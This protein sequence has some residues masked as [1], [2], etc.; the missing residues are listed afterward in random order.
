MDPFAPPP[1]RRRSNTFARTRPIDVD[2]VIDVDADDDTHDHSSGAAVQSDTHTNLG[3]ASPLLPSPDSFYVN[4]HPVRSSFQEGSDLLS[5]HQPSSAFHSAS[6]PYPPTAQIFTRTSSEEAPNDIDTGHTIGPNMVD[7]SNGVTSA[8][9][10]ISVNLSADDLVHQPA[11]NGIGKINPNNTVQPAHAKG[12][13][14]QVLTLQQIPSSA[15]LDL[16]E[17]NVT[18]VDQPLSPQNQDVRATF[19]N[20]GPSSDDPMNNS[21]CPSTPREIRTF[22]QPNPRQT[23][24]TSVPQSTTSV[25]DSPEICAQDNS[26]LQAS[27][28]TPSEPS[29]FDG[30]KNGAAGSH[31]LKQPPSESRAEP[32]I[33]NNIPRSCSTADSE[34]KG[35]PAFT[36]LDSSLAHAETIRFTRIKS[37]LTEAKRQTSVD[38]DVKPA[39]PPA[40]AGDTTGTNEIEPGPTAQ[41][42][43]NKASL[44]KS[45]AASD[46]D[47]GVGTFSEDNFAK[48]TPS[49]PNAKDTDLPS[50]EDMNVDLMRAPDHEITGEAILSTH[51]VTEGVDSLTCVEQGQALALQLTAHGNTDPVTGSEVYL[52]VN[53]KDLFHARESHLNSVTNKLLPV[54]HHEVSPGIKTTTV[55]DLAPAVKTTTVAD[56]APAVNSHPPIESFTPPR[57]NHGCQDTFEGIEM[58]GLNNSFAKVP[59]TTTRKPDAMHLVEREMCRTKIPKGNLNQKQSK[60]LERPANVEIVRIDSPIDLDGSSSAEEEDPIPIYTISDD[61]DGEHSDVE[62]VKE[63]SADSVVSDNVKS[64]MTRLHFENVSVAIPR[65]TRCEPPSADDLAVL[66]AIADVFKEDAVRMKKAHVDCNRSRNVLVVVSTVHRA[67]K[68][69]RFFHTH[70]E[71]NA[72]RHGIQNRMRN[73][74]AATRRGREDAPFSS[75]F[76]SSDV[77]VTTDKAV[78]RHCD[79]H[80]LNLRDVSLIVLD[81]AE[82]MWNRSHPASRFLR[83][84]YRALPEFVRPR[85]LAIVRRAMRPGE[86]APIEY[87][88]F[89][90]FVPSASRGVVWKSCYGK[91]PRK[92]EHELLDVEYVHYRDNCDETIYIQGRKLAPPRATDRREFT[93]LDSVVDE[94]GPLGVALYRNKAMFKRRQR[95]NGTESFRDESNKKIQLSG[96]HDIL[97]LSQK[98]LSLLN[99][100]YEAYRASTEV[101]ALMAIIYAGKPA[102]ACAVCE[103]INSMPVFTD[104]IV[105]V[106]VGNSRSEAKSLSSFDGFEYRDWQGEDTDDDEVSSFTSREIDVLIVSENYVKGAANRPLPACPLVIRFDGS[107][108]NPMIDGGGGRCRVIVFKDHTRRGDPTAEMGGDHLTDVEEV[109]IEKGNQLSPSV[110]PTSHANI[111]DVNEKPHVPHADSTGRIL[112]AVESRPSSQVCPGPRQHTSKEERRNL[113]FTATETY[114]CR[115]PASLLGL[116]SERGGRVYLYRILLYSEGTLTNASAAPKFMQSGLE[117]FA[118]AL[119]EKLFEQDTVLSLKDYHIGCGNGTSVEGSIRLIYQGL[120]TLTREKLDMVQRY[121]TRLFNLVDSTYTEEEF[122]WDSNL[123]KSANVNDPTHISFLRRYLVLPVISCNNKTEANP[124]TRT[125]EHADNPVAELESR[126]AILKRYF[127]DPPSNATPIS[128]IVKVDWKAIE[129]I[130][131]LCNRDKHVEELNPSELVDRAGLTTFEGQ[132]L[133]SSFPHE[134][135]VLAGKLQYDV[136]PLSTISRSRKFF[137]NDDGTLKPCSDLSYLTKVEATEESIRRQKCATGSK[138][139]LLDPDGVEVSSPECKGDPGFVNTSKDPKLIPVRWC[140]QDQALVPTGEPVYAEKEASRFD[141]ERNVLKKRKYWTC[142]VRYKIEYY[143]NRFYREHIRQLDQPLLLAA[144]PR[145]ANLSEFVDIIRG[146]RISDIAADIVQSKGEKR[147]LVPELCRTYPISSGMLFLPCA[148]HFIEQHLSI[149][150]LRSLFDPHVGVVGETAHLVRA[151]TPC[152]RNNKTN[153]ER[154]EFLGDSLFKLACTT[155]LMRLFVHADEGILT[156]ERNKA[157]ANTVLKK[158]GQKMRIFNYF[159]FHQETDSD[160]R[161][162]GT[163]TRG[164]GRKFQ[165]KAVADVVE[166]LCGA[167]FEIGVAQA[168][169]NTGSRKSSAKRAKLE[170]SLS[171]DGSDSSEFSDSDT[172]WIQDSDSEVPIVIDDENGSDDDIDTGKKTKKRKTSETGLGMNRRRFTVSSVCHG[173]EVGAKFLE[174]IGALDS[175]EPTLEELLTTTIQSINPKSAKVAVEG[176]ELFPSDMRLNNSNWDQKYSKVEGILDYEFRQRSLLICALTHG[177]YIKAGGKVPRTETYERLEFLGDAVADFFVACHLYERYPEC[178]P[179]ELT[180]LKG[181]VV[182][183]ESFARVTV[184]NGIHNFLD[185]NSGT[186]AMEISAFVQSLPQDLTVGG[187]GSHS[188]RKKDYGEVTAPKALGDVFE[189][190]VGAVFVDAGL[191]PAWRVCS[192]LLRDSLRINADRER[193]DLHPINELADKVRR[194]WGIVGDLKFKDEYI[195]QNKKKVAIYILGEK[196]ATGIGNIAKRAR[197]LAARNA[198]TFLSNED[199]NSEG[200]KMRA[201]LMTKGLQ[202]LRRVRQCMA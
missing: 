165:M 200:A 77:V 7:A 95:A 141:C 187:D 150:E 108:A 123:A 104:L 176:D 111:V 134:S 117:N 61:D 82:Y 55:A 101:D 167:Y 194:V 78:C 120:I 157:V 162:P 112:D 16:I 84:Y 65:F 39:K 91:G 114:Y 116:D 93:P 128:S 9:V 170:V 51:D 186:L 88:T 44:P 143:F 144:L 36:Q 139:N 147:Y 97:G 67:D 100:L 2:V 106:V 48:A 94:V 135:V 64:A 17:N 159:R 15:P 130:L 173:Y 145:R 172:Q 57:L 10:C 4:Q 105:R 27:V 124:V 188:V 155:R 175:K 189:A 59:P 86:T 46:F 26:A 35:H 113:E 34:G 102:V 60:P 22:E 31:L 156:K 3:S 90:R 202:E 76:S 126:E 125:V 184:T 45:G 149:C 8:S 13:F 19:T 136:S 80:S 81:T 56:M 133:F 154:L 18:V 180:D 29:I 142:S 99:E 178:S 75:V 132:I 85:I 110:I 68:L 70:S 33:K 196:V 121:T 103:V 96:D 192:K 89:T 201:W 163:D 62:I 122:V 152:F 41:M 53:Q 138:R 11:N 74:R 177:S 183:N 42:N 169:A 119:S 190:I 72:I 87:N 146:K 6:I 83:D 23:T 179:G 21:D 166:A 153:Y 140:E 38:V 158:C 197:L 20:N 174:R 161:P 71:L 107:E 127:G 12:G 195:S 24:H 25:R 52:S 115:P 168:L 73:S 181:N 131:S 28:A 58:F 47:S 49:F 37:S 1:R 198:L 54:Q 69:D 182:S 79:R 151:V 32:N 109:R 30:L 5:V 50:T 148:L 14:K 193:H 98:M 66:Q 129:M 63:F 185:H 171:Y 160:W 43:E 40:R 118:V 191:G 137:L 164:P 199:I 92:L